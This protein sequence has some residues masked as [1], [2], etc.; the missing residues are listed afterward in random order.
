[1]LAGLLDWLQCIS[2]FANKVADG[3]VDE[4]TNILKETIP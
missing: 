3:I 2:F 4:E 1:M